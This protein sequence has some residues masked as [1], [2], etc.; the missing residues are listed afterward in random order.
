MFNVQLWKQSGVSLEEF[1][2]LKWHVRRYNRIQYTLFVSL[3]LSMGLSA[4]NQ[5]PNYLEPITNYYLYVYVKEFRCKCSIRPSIFQT[6]IQYSVFARCQYQWCNYILSSPSISRGF[7]LFYS[8]SYSTINRSNA[9]FVLEPFCV[10]KYDQWSQS[11]ACVCVC[12]H[13]QRSITINNQHS[14]DVFSIISS[15]QQWM[16]L[17]R[18]AMRS[19]FC[20]SFSFFN[21]WL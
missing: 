11:R 16:D 21:I 18:W 20:A 9:S 4:F 5:L 8:N 1:E 19:T 7:K 10:L 15:R 14:C 17:I 13:D 12:V 2:I 3:G 6:C